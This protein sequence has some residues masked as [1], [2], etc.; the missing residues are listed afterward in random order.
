MSNEPDGAIR[1]RPAAAADE[2][3]LIELAARLTAF[4]LPPWRKPSDIATA[5]AREMM[6]AVR[7]A[8]PDN[9]VLIAERAGV[10]VGCLHVL[11]T[12]DFFGTRHAHISVLATTQAAEGSG[13]GRALLQHAEQWARRRALSL[14][15]LN[16]F[17]A[18]D[19]A[20]RFYDRAG[21]TPE[22]MKYVKPLQLPD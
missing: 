18:N 13:V 22:I 16:V 17:A 3:L 5:D 9:E 6:E 15:T 8:A 4:D 1:I 12:T 21:L 10:P 7:G 14:L 11:A 19:R 20:R 2:V